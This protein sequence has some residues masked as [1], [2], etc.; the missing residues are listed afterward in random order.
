M[1]FR[2][3]VRSAAAQTFTDYEIIVVYPAGAD[4]RPFLRRKA[5]GKPVRWVT[6]R[7]PRVGAARNSG[8]DAA[9]G[10]WVAF[11]DSD[12]LWFPHKLSRQ[13]SYLSGRRRC[14]VV[15]S[16][17][18]VFFRP[19]RTPDPMGTFE[20]ERLS[21][22][23]RPVRGR[24]TEEKLRRTGAFILTSSLVMRK[25]IWEDVGPFNESLF[26]CEDDE[27]FL[28]ASRGVVHVGYIPHPLLLYR[29]KRG[30]ADARYFGLKETILLD[31]KGKGW[32]ND[33][34]RTRRRH[35]KKDPKDAPAIEG[36]K[37]LQEALCRA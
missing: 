9:R 11:L 35:E 33:T 29:I 22:L 34:P 4:T 8:M 25:T 24:I 23:G 18:I 21:A 5:A 2:A 1:F 14:D 26:A 3:A 37:G 7:G 16:D 27:F 17:A 10:E 31:T 20:A 15:H 13:V 6:S 36:P 12:D 30:R 32:S 28:R 19:T